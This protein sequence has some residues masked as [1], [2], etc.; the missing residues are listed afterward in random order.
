MTEMITLHQRQ[1]NSG[2]T[3]ATRPE[4]GNGVMSHLTWVNGKLITYTMMPVHSSK[5]KHTCIINTNPTYISYFKLI[6]TKHTQFKHTNAMISQLKSKLTQ[7][8]KWFQDF[9]YKRK[10]KMQLNWFDDFRV[11]IVRSKMNDLMI[12]GVKL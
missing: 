9:K 4:N 11:E 1:L 3:K 7:K 2:T 10:E 6:C 5:T 12:F 8:I